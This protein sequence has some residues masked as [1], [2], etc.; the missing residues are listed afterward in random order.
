MTKPKPQEKAALQ[1]RVV[2]PLHAY[3]DGCF[4][5]MMSAMVGLDPKAGEGKKK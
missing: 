1:N 5:R 4:V 3:S 2:L